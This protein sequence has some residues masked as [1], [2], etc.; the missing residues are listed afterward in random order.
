M[1]NCFCFKT[2]YTE[3]PSVERY[4]S[5]EYDEE[6]E[7]MRRDDIAIKSYYTQCI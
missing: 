3:E 4:P 2:E 7:I 5:Y 6:E 1:G